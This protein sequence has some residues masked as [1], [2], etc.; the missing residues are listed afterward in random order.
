MAIDNL[1]RMLTPDLGRAYLEIVPATNAPPPEPLDAPQ[2]R[3]AGVR[4]D[5]LALAGFGAVFAAVKLNRTAAFDLAITLRIQGRRVPAL[6]RLMIAVSWP[7]FPPQS[8]IIPSGII[9]F[10]W[11]RRYRL[12]AALQAAAWGTAVL[13]TLV[14]EVTRRQRPLAPEVQVVVAKLGGSSFPSGHVLTYVGVYGFAAHLANSMVRPRWLRALVV[15]P[16]VGLVALVGPSR[17]YQ[18]HHWPTDVLASYL[19]G[20]ASLLGL[21]ALY[22]R[23]KWRETPA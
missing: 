19:L 22:N 9:A 3:R 18:G 6:G 17:I 12:E 11:L 7:G 16:L 8:R 2:R 5:L 13:S 15:A 20:I 1:K 23:L 21:T 14:K 4:F 10:L